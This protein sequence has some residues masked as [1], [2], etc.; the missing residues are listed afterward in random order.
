MSKVTKVQYE[1]PG[2]RIR[3]FASV[4][5]DTQLRIKMI[6]TDTRVGFV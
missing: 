2:E 3:T 5:G 4:N 1:L 6:R